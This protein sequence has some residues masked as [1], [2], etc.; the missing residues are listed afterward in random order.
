MSDHAARDQEARIDA[1]LRK[2][3]GNLHLVPEARTPLEDLFRLEDGDEEIEV[4]REERLLT[5][6][7]VMGYIFEAGPEPL[8]VLRRIFAITKAVR[9]ELIGDMSLEDISV[10]CADGSK[11]T[12][13]ARIERIYNKPVAE[14]GAKGVTAAFQKRSGAYAEA[15]LGNKNRRKGKR[16]AK[17]SKGKRP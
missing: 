2:N 9:P 11:A 12:V 6:R 16:K 5:F 7:L 1:I 17:N 8:S 4:R 14:T 15:Q 3:A 13:S 10:I